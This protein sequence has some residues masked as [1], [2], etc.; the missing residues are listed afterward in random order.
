VSLNE[1]SY[2]LAVPRLIQSQYLAKLSALLRQAEQLYSAL[3]RYR[4][5]VFGRQTEAETPPYLRL[6]RLAKLSALLRQAAQLYWEH[7]RHPG[8]AMLSM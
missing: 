4:V 3:L 2:H 6:L 8:R 5:L 7:S 1:Q